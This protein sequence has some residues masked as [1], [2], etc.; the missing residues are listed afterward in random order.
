MNEFS[1]PSTYVDH[2][3][4]QHQGNRRAAIAALVSQHEVDTQ[5]RRE[6]VEILKEGLPKWQV[7]F[8][9]FPVE[10]M[11]DIP[12]TWEDI[13]WHNDACPSFMAMCQGPDGDPSATYDTMRIW[14]AE[15][16]P[17]LRD[18]PNIGR[19]CVSFDGASD[20]T[21][22]FQSDDWEE[23]LNYVNERVELGQRYK[24]VVG[25]NPFLDEPSITPE[26]VRQTLKEFEEEAKANG[27]DF[28]GP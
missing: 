5:L 24:T 23:I 1:S 18:L 28:R 4:K 25:Y 22:E 15:A 13:S 27:D 7:E 12:D 26:E 16:N 3:L 14:V 21:F 19:F 9:H 20:E 11:P 2:L 6:A 10:D 8:P 17:D